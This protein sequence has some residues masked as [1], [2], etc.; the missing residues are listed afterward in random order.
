LINLKVQ[1]LPLHREIIQDIAARVVRLLNNGSTLLSPPL[2]QRLAVDFGRFD[3]SLGG[4]SGIMIDLGRRTFGLGNKGRR[5]FLCF[6]EVFRASLLRLGKNLSTSFLSFS[7]D[8]TGFFVR[9]AEDCGALGAEG[10]RERGFVKSGIRS[11]ALCFDK[12]LVHF[13]QP[14]LEVANFSRDNFEVKANFLGIE[15][16]FSKGREVRTHNFHRRRTW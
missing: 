5:S 4:E 12:L 3:Q 15:A 10:T 6:D 1:R 2:D 11:A 9:G 16:T 13:S 8:P 7:R 14:I